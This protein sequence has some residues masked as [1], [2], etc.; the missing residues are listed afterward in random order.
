MDDTSKNTVR[1]YELSDE[2]GFLIE[3]G[4]AMAKKNPDS[5]YVGACYI[6]RDIRDGINRVA[7]DIE[8]S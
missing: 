7:S 4:R 3:A 8:N 1:L 6:L 5:C 2:L